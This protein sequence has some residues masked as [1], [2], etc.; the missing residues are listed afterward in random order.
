MQRLGLH[1]VCMTLNLKQWSV[2]L[3]PRNSRLECFDHIVEM[4]VEKIKFPKK[5]VSVLVHVGQVSTK[6]APVRILRRNKQHILVIYIVS[7]SARVLSELN[8]FQLWRVIFMSGAK[9]EG[10][11]HPF[12]IWCGDHVS[13]NFRNIIF[14]FYHSLK[15]LSRLKLI[16]GT[17]LCFTCKTSHVFGIIGQ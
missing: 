1:Q 3:R 11:K 2:I 9:Y 12:G 7:W 8:L 15:K 10:K 14:K 16:Q 6:I 13:N 4:S 5:S 17:V